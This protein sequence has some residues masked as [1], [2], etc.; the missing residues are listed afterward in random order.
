MGKHDVTSLDPFLQRKMLNVNVRTTFGAFACICHHDSSSIVDPDHCA[1][2]LMKSQLMKDGTKH[3]S[4]LES[5]DRGD[6]LSFGET[7]PAG[8]NPFG[9]I[10]DGSSSE[11]ED[12][13]THRTPSTKTGCSKE[14]R[15]TPRWV[16]P[17]YT[18]IRPRDKRALV[19]S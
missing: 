16:T 6:E 3:L 17:L 9:T 2:N 8:G 13:A 10:S 7:G 5:T 14:F 12:V 19:Q 4:S 11:N 1:A 15:K 18:K